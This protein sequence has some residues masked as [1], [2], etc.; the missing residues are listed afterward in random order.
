MRSRAKGEI[1]VEWE[2][3]NLRNFE[4]R[5]REGVKTVLIKWALFLAQIVESSL[6]STTA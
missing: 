5:Q 3:L 4:K 1:A 6:N 2:L